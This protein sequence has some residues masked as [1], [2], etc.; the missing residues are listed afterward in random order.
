MKKKNT[1]LLSKNAMLEQEDGGWG[2]REVGKGRFG[3]F[4]LVILWSKIFIDYHLIRNDSP[5][6][7]S[8][9]VVAPAIY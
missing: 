6:V 1:H 8:A 5:A 3:M 7:I 4:V 9:P 2:K